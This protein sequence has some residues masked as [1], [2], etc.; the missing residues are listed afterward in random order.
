MQLIFLHCTYM[1]PKLLCTVLKT[2]QNLFSNMIASKWDTW[3][4]E[5]NMI[6]SFSYLQNCIFLKCTVFKINMLA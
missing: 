6:V 1:S 4:V 3:S 5:Q 2:K